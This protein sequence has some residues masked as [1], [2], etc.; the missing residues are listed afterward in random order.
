M[1]L[2]IIGCEYSGTTTLA[3]GISEWAERAMG[4]KYH[5][6]DHWKVPHLRHG[7]P[8]E[9]Q[10]QILALTPYLKESYQRF[11]LADHMQDEYYLLGA[12]D[13]GDLAEGNHLVVGMHIDEAVYSS[14]YYGY[15]GEGEFGDR[16]SYARHIEKRMVEMAPDT[17]LVLLTCAPDVI[18]KR[19]KAD[20]AH[21]FARA[22]RGRGAGARTVR[23]GVRAVSDQQ[24]VHHRHEHRDTRGVRGGVPGEIRAVHDGPRP[25]ADTRSP[26]QSEGRVAACLTICGGKLTGRA[27]RNAN[28]SRR[29]SRYRFKAGVVR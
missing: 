19:M 9:E 8:V 16:V 17:V 27:A 25:D 24:Q 13:T 5:F 22:G 28:R 18:R 20:P 29:H 11:H 14:L 26:G 15:G 10:E 3:D 21:E 7:L 23:G 12:E 6:H 4:R 1:H 2:V